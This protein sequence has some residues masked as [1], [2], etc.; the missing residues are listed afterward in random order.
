[1]GA[2]TEIEMKERKGPRRGRADRPARRSEEASLPAAVSPTSPPASALDKIKG[3]NPDQGAGIKIVRRALE[4]PLRQ[5]VANAGAEPSVVLNKVA[6]GRATSASMRRPEAY[7][8]LRRGRWSSP[9]PKVAPRRRCRHAAFPWPACSSRPKRMV[10]RAWWT[11]KEGASPGVTAWAEGG[12][13][14]M[15]M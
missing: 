10:A 1:V 8:D 6:E 13:P 5:I 4:E 14:G 7:G 2:A 15:D 3:D 9:T 11:E 12:M